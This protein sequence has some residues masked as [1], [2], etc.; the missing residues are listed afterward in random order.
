MTHT[1]G[2]VEVKPGFL[3]NPALKLRLHSGGSG[4]LAPMPSSWAARYSLSTFVSQ[5]VG[6][7]IRASSASC[8]D[9]TY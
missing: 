7:A 2:F 4:G 1:D 3:V 8:I 9:A 5:M 6:S